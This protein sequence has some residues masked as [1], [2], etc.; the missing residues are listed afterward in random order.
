MKLSEILAKPFKVKGGGT[1]NLKGISKHIVDKE[2]GGSGETTDDIDVLAKYGCVILHEPESEYAKKIVFGDKNKLITITADDIINYQT[3]VNSMINSHTESGDIE[4]HI[5]ANV[6]IGSSDKKIIIYDLI[7]HSLSNT[8][9]EINIKTVFIDPNIY[10]IPLIN[11]FDGNYMN[12]QVLIFNTVGCIY[13]PYDNINNCPVDLFGLAFI[14]SDFYN[15]E[16]ETIS[17]PAIYI[18]TTAEPSK[19]FTSMARFVWVEITHGVH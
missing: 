7:P 6:D 3:E 13:T 18:D 8:T 2:V 1:L 17:M 5:L 19:Y 10:I 11:I 12:Q 4:S 14:A 15:L 9:L 16:D